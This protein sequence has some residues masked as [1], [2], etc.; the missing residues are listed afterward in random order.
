MVDTPEVP[1]TGTVDQPS[2]PGAVTQDPRITELQQ[3]MN[4]DPLADAKAAGI[5]PIQGGQD[6]NARPDVVGQPNAA[7]PA[8]AAPPAGQPAPAAP[9]SASGT[10]AVGAEATPPAMT[11]QEQAVLMAQLLIP[12]A[13]PPPSG[14]PSAG[15]Q[16]AQPS[17]GA[18]PAAPAAEAQF[19]PFTADLNIPPAIEAAIFGEDPANRGIAFRMLLAANNNA[20]IR[21]VL[22][23]VTSS[24]LPKQM[25]EFVGQREQQAQ[26][27][28]DRDTF[29][30]EAPD[31]RAVPNLVQRA[32]GI[33][34]QQKQMLNQA[35]AWDEQTRKQVQNL[36]RS[37]LQQLGG[38]VPVPALPNPAAPIQPNPGNAYVAGASRPEG[39]GSPGAVTPESE[40]ADLIGWG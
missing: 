39:F 40:L 36:A 30:A 3:F 24:V 13:A 10:P 37:A 18:Q 28:R 22:S 16:T 20:V 1:A 4:S 6:T 19:A 7:P 17:G 25:Q 21:E 29:Y 12:A 38:S 23:H 31:L 26:L 14:Q 9:A 8:V 32:V 34:A 15:T 27:V 35:W 2:T 11:A 5:E 33:V